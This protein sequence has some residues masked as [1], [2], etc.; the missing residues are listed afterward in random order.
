[1]AQGGVRTGFSFFG[2]V[3]GVMAMLKFKDEWDSRCML[4]I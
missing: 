3:G 1:M 4:L 2:L